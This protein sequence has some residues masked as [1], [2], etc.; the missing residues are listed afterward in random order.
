MIRDTRDADFLQ[1]VQSLIHEGWYCLVDLNKSKN[2]DYCDQIGMPYEM[3]KF[4]V[5]EVL[6][7]LELEDKYS[8]PHPDIHRKSTDHFYEFKGIHREKKV[9]LRFKIDRDKQRIYVNSFHGD[10][11]QLF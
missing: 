9:F 2:R 5:R 11:K 4:E 8:G 1:E 7:D 6:L 10:Q 3:A